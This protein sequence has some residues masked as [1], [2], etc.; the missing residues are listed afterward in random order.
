[1][2]LSQRWLERMHIYTSSK[3]SLDE[4][5]PSWHHWQESIGRL[6][7]TELREDKDWGGKEPKSTT[8]Q[9]QVALNI[10]C[11]KLRKL[12][13]PLFSYCVI[14]Q[15]AFLSPTLFV[16]V[17]VLQALVQVAGSGSGTYVGVGVDRSQTWDGRAVP[18][19]SQVARFCVNRRASIKNLH[20]PKV[21]STD[22]EPQNRQKQATQ[23]SLT[24]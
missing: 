8:E 7:G 16:E 5:K 2:E 17:E 19:W 24:T 21:V 22:E 15:Q 9:S 12:S 13:S 6:S 3:C 11:A 14:S 23:W 4:G 10:S 18:Y 20:K 1:M